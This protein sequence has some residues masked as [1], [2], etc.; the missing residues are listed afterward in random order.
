MEYATFRYDT[1]EVENGLDEYF[2]NYRIR[3]E[4]RFIFFPGPLATFLAP[5]RK[6]WQVEFKNSK[7]SLPGC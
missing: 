5:L 6:R 7:I 4:L 2:G 3:Q 1:A